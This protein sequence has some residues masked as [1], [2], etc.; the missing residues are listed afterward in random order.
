MKTACH[1][2]RSH[3]LLVFQQVLFEY[4]FKFSFFKPLW[5]FNIEM[6]FKSETI[7]SN[8]TK[9]PSTHSKMS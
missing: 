5:L 7:F 6:V 3:L 4:L 8:T 1:L 2:A 9:P